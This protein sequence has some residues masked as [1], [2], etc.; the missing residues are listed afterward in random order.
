MKYYTYRID[1]SYLNIKGRFLSKDWNV[2]Y[3]YTALVDK[4]FKFRVDKPA[5]NNKPLM[6]FVI[7]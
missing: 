6:E 7:D 1:R 3:R 2:R 5:H 4:E